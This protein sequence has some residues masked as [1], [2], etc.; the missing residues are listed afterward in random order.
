MNPNHGLSC[1][2]WTY[3]TKCWYCRAGIYVHQCTCGSVVLFDCL[4]GGWPI[5]ICGTRATTLRPI[6]SDAEWER[7]RFQERI[8]AIQPA[9]EQWVSRAPE[10]HLRDP[11]QKLVV[12]LQELPKQTKRITTLDREGLFEL[13]AMKIQGGANLYAQ[14]TLRDTE[15]SPHRVYP[16]I[17]RKSSLPSERLRRNMRVGVTL[18]ARGLQRVE[19]FVVEMVALPGDT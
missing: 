18:E 16:A 13:A 15:S 4:G 1:Q 17:V 12:T 9:N 3:P 8:A 19:W 5:H 10:R 14:V 11:P 7:R 2:S 6:L